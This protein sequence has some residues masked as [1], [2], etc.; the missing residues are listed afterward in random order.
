MLTCA[1]L[2]T[3]QSPFWSNWRYCRVWSFGN[4][5]R[6]LLFLYN[7]TKCA[8]WYSPSPVYKS[9]VRILNNKKIFLHLVSEIAHAESTSKGHTRSFIHSSSIIKI[10]WLSIYLLPALISGKGPAT[11]TVILSKLSLKYDQFWKGTFYQ[12]R[13]CR[14]DPLTLRW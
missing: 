12:T 2:L 8:R 14:N 4:R 9:N 1:P 11:S 6:H 3:S 10:S 5:F 13:T 7:Q